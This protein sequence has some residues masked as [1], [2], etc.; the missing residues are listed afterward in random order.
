[1]SID[2]GLSPEQVGELTLSLIALGWTVI[3]HFQHKDTQAQLTALTGKQPA[4]NVVSRV[5]TAVAAAIRNEAQLQPPTPT[6]TQP[7]P[8]AAATGGIQK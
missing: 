3:Q 1:M 8:Q 5:I 7:T 2:I 4:V 6:N